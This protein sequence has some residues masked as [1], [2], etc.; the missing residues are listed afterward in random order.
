MCL[1]LFYFSLAILLI[2]LKKKKSVVEKLELSIQNADV[3]G[4]KKNSIPN[5]RQ[6]AA[7]K[8][9]KFKVIPEKSDVLLK[10]RWLFITLN[11]HRH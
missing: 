10:V 7:W 3:L 1:R 9:S 11:H 6:T 8:D 5:E 4:I 2:Y